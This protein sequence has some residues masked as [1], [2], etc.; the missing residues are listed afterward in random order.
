[1][2]DAEV[3]KQFAAALAI[4][5]TPSK[6]APKMSNDDKLKFYALFKQATVGKVNTPQPSKMKMVDRAKWD[7]WN[8]LGAMT[9]TEA[10]KKFVAEFLKLQPQAKL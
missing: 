5:S 9:Q 3:D 4:S 1:M 6:D 7:A 2:V 8:K 10:K